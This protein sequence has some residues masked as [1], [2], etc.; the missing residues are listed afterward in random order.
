MAIW[1][2]VASGAAAALGFAGQ[3]QAN[4]TNVR[5]AREQMRFQERMSNTSY[6]RAVAD[7]RLA[8]INPM[9]AYM[10]G[11]ASSPGGASATMHDVIGP[12]VSS[13]QSGRRLALE[14]EATKS[15]IRKNDADA[16]ASQSSGNL[17]QAR[18]LNESA[19]IQSVPGGPV[20]PFEVLRRQKLLDLIASQSSA[21]SSTAA[22]NRAGLPRAEYEGTRA[23][24]IADQLQRALFGTG[25][26]LIDV[27]KA[28][29]PKF[30]PKG[31]RR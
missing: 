8:G 18:V 24:A 2:A 9:L 16:F 31:R 30:V 21:A 6:Q 28:L 11:G 19:G 29:A 25:G 27:P 15:Q 14:I 26:G 1:P 17:S 23:A 13:A 5:L 22:L 10:Q 7:M 4:A 3:S 20:T 12:A